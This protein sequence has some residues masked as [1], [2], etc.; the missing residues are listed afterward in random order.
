MFAEQVFPQPPQLAVSEEGSTHW[1]KQAIWPAGHDSVVHTPDVQT[2]LIPQAFPHPPQL[3]R[4][5]AMS[6]H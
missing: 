4:S 6:V 3:L 1:P 2:S 5:A